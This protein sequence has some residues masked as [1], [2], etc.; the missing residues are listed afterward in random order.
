MWYDG[1]TVH[2]PVILFNSKIKTLVAVVLSLSLKTTFQGG[3]VYTNIGRE[4]PWYKFEQNRNTII[5]HIVK[6]LN[7]TVV[8]ICTGNDPVLDRIK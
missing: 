6:L 2:V 7:M 5:W 4:C 3:T 1:Y 8:K